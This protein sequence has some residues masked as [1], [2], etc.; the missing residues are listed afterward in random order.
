[1]LG[2]PLRESPIAQAH[3]GSGSKGTQGRA[4]F[5][6]GSPIANVEMSESTI[7]P[8]AVL[9]ALKHRD[10]RL[11]SLRVQ[12]PGLKTISE[13]AAESA[14][15]QSLI[16]EPADPVTPPPLEVEVVELTEPIMSFIL[17]D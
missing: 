13:E 14:F 16:H 1:M 5:R 8:Y 4:E 6:D 12:T 3:S 9:D 17:K 15:K 7:E 2:T 11:D 10:N